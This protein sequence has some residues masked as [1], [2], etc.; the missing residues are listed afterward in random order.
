M[1][2]SLIMTVLI[3]IF[4][5][6][7]GFYSGIKYQQSN[8]SSFANGNFRQMNNGQQQGFKEENKNG[9]RQVTGEIINSDNKSIIVKLSDGSSKIIL[10]S[11][12]TKVNKAS[13]ATIADLKVGEKIGV[14]GLENSDGT[15][16]AENI[17]LNPLFRNI[18]KKS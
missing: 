4:V 2:N 9:P 5:G 6:A 12:T 13:E 10:I 15:I 8:R 11:G 1:K 17:Q 18:D 14:F 7:V 16:T 3:A